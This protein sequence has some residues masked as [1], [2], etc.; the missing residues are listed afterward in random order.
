MNRGQQMMAVM[1][2]LTLESRPVSQLVGCDSELAKFGSVN[3]MIELQDMIGG[4][5]VSF[6]IVKSI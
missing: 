4:A 5:L 6:I 2:N 3:L 1:K